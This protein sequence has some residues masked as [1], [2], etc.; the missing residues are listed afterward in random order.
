MKN[1]KRYIL[2]KETTEDE[3]QKIKDECKK[4]DMDVVNE[5]S[6][7]VQYDVKSCAIYAVDGSMVQYNKEEGRIL[8][9]Q[10]CPHF[11]SEHSEDGKEKIHNKI[12]CEIRMPASLFRITA[13]TIMDEI[14][15]YD[16]H[17]K[18]KAPLVDF[19]RKERDHIMFG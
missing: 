4:N 15:D 2:S 8:F 10:S 19:L 12:V 17:E 6:I 11:K 5:E 18:K 7:D 16:E 14:N 9:V 3:I 13:N 1:K